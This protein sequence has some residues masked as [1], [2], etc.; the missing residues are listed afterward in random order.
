MVPVVTHTWMS[1][2]LLPK[3]PVW[4][5]AT[6]QCLA[7]GKPYLRAEVLGGSTSAVRDVGGASLRVRL[8]D[9]MTDGGYLFLVS[10]PSLHCPSGAGWVPAIAGVPGSRYGTS[11]ERLAELMVM[12]RPLAS[13]KSDTGEPREVTF[14]PEENLLCLFPPGSQ[15]HLKPLHR[16]TNFFLGLNAGRWLTIRMSEISTK[17]CQFLA[18]TQVDEGQSTSSWSD[19]VLQSGLEGHYSKEVEAPPEDSTYLFEHYGMS[20]NSAL[21]PEARHLHKL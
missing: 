15:V 7:V 14:L 5:A 6:A 1:S 12:A 19:F 4:A 13:T 17:A 9:V 11:R 20:N 8:P 3:I 16:V 21:P 18:E 2:P 10:S